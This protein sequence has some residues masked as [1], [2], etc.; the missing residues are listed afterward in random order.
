MTKKEIQKIYKLVKEY[1][2]KYVIISNPDVIFNEEVITCLKEHLISYNNT[3]VAS[4]VMLNKVGV[5]EPLTI[6]P[7]DGNKYKIFFHTKSRN[8]EVGQTVLYQ[9]RPFANQWKELGLCTV[10]SENK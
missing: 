1:H 9:F 6:T 8:G 3:A 5:R 4:P 10:G 2:E 7:D